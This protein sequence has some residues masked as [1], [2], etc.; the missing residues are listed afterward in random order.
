VATALALHL[1]ATE[2]QHN[3]SVLAIAALR[4]VHRIALP[5]L[6]TI[7]MYKNVQKRKP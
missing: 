2:H 5:L 1:A 7:T 4:M 3:H 6:A